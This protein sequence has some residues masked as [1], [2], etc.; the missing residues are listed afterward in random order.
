LQTASEHGSAKRSNLR[1]ILQLALVSGVW[2]LG[3]ARKQMQYRNCVLLLPAFSSRRI[4]QHGSYALRYD[5]SYH[6]DA[7]SVC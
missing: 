2:V 7:I 6:N 4:V 1:R 5:S 3:S